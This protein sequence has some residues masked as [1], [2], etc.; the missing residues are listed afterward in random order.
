MVRPAVKRRALLGA[1]GL[2]AALPWLAAAQPARP[3]L[4]IVL[5]TGDSEDD[6]PA[7]R[8]FFDQMRR[9]GWIEDQNIVYERIFGK[10]MRAYLEG[11]ARSAVSRTPDLI[12]ASVAS[13]ALAVLEETGSIPVVFMT[14]SDPV[15]GGLVASLAR[16]GR[17]ATGTFQP[18]G[19]V[20][21]KRLELIRE[22]FPRATR[23]GAVFDRRAA[24]IQQ[25]KELYQATAARMGFD[26][27]AVEFT[28]FEVVPKALARFRKDKITAVLVAGSLT[29][30]PRRREVV[31]AAMRNGIVLLTTRADWVESGAVLSYGA[32]V[33]EALRRCA[34]ISDRILK[35]A[36]AASIPVEEVTKF[37]LA[38]NLR[39]AQALAIDIPKPVIERADR[40][41]K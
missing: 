25:Q 28:N 1:L 35:G 10:G 16:P 26:L 34:R 6:E 29:L 33:A 24:G 27:H 17:N 3:M 14:S 23:I 11:L 32:E 41:I 4:V 38:V 22:T 30:F 40:V 39:S 15:A 19:D 2:A 37:E 9:L 18:P 5:F 20:A 12:F 31:N 8:S 7:T 13:I 21:P 36:P